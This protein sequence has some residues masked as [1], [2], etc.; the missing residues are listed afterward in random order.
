MKAFMTID[1]TKENRMKKRQ[2][3]VPRRDADFDIW[4]LILVNYVNSKCLGTNP[5]WTHIP[6]AARL[7]L[8][9]QLAAWSAALATARTIPTPANTEEKN[10]VRMAVEKFFRNFVNQYL[11]YPPV[12][13]E[14]RSNMHIH[15]RDSH[16]T[17]ISVPGTVP[18]IISLVIISG[19]RIK[20]HFRD[21]TE[22]RSQAI[23]YG[24]SGCLLSFSWGDERI[25]D[26]TQL[27]ETRLMT[28]SPWILNLPTTAERSWLSVAARWQNKKGD[29]GPWGEIHCTV[30]G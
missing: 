21:E 18:F 6:E 12:T 14:D 19:H 8:G 5:A 11:R 4:L 28:R 16:S 15:N 27:R 2:D 24:F 23:P 22:A 29:L 20:I 7:A 17:E 1:R 9:M 13:D 25:S 10:L 26:V 30:V 3:Y